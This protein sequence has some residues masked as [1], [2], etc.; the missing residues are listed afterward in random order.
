MIRKDPI[1]MNFI[2]GSGTTYHGK[3][4]SFNVIYLDPELMIPLEYESWTFDLDKA[5]SEDKPTWNRKLNYRETYN[6]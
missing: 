1:G 2:V 4:P 3:P 5:N 6:L